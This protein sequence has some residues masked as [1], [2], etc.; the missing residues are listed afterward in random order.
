[1]PALLTSEEILSTFKVSPR[2]LRRWLTA[3]DFPRPI[4]TGRSRR[5]FAADIEAYLN[6]KKYEASK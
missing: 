5:W 1:M 6:A 4:K 2:T 3:S